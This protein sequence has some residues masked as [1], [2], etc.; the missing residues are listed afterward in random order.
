MSK[1]FVMIFVGF[2]LCF[3]HYSENV[4]SEK[5]VASP[6]RSCIIRATCGRA[7]DTE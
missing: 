7:D 2:R 6:I 3:L 1:T 5:T 4:V